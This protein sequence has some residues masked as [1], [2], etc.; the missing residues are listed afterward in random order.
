MKPAPSKE[1]AQL[2]KEF[3]DHSCREFM[4]K[5]RVS[6]KD[7]QGFVVLWKSNV[8]HLYDVANETGRLANDYINR[9]DQGL[10]G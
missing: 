4:G 3:Y 10:H 1:Q 6:S 9:H 7:P 8:Q 5:D 2:M